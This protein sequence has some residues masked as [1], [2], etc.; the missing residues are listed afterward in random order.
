MINSHF[1]FDPLYSTKSLEDPEYD[2]LQGGSEKS[3]TKPILQQTPKNEQQ[4]QRW[5][6]LNHLFDH[7]YF[8]TEELRNSG[9]YYTWFNGFLDY[10]LIAQ[11]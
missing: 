7:L 10:L 5:I 6:H 1:H 3:L 8:C 2:P 4:Y 11:Q 9:L